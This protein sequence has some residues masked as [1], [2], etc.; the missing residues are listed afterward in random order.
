[1]SSFAFNKTAK[2]DYEILEAFEAGIILTGH[3]AKSIKMGHVDLT[4]SRATARG[5][6]LTVIGMKIPSFQPKNAP[7]EYDLSRT[8]KLLLNKKEIEYLT[9]KLQ[10]G[11]TLIPLSVYTKKG[12]IKLELGLGKLRKKS[13]KR[14]LIKKRETEREIRT[15]PK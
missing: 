12:I 9:G 2:F 14:E 13:D 3:E 15:F 11:L 5:T 4:G 6:A 10:S 7:P 1:M 8:R